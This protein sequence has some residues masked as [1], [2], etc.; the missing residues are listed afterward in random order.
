MTE[1]LLGEM[2]VV[3]SYH[4]VLNLGAFFFITKQPVKRGKTVLKK[5]MILSWIYV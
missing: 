3:C 2:E 1:V 5:T 4:H